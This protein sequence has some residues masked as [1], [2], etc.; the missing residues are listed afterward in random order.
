MI[1]N[2][3]SMFS[4]LIT[5][6]FIAV[7]SATNGLQLQFTEGDQI[8]T[9]WVLVTGDISVNSSACEGPLN[10]ET[11]M[12]NNQYIVRF[13]CAPQIITKPIGPAPQGCG[14]QA[15][16]PIRTR[17]VGGREAAAHS[18]PWLVSLQYAGEHFCGG[19]LIVSNEFHRAK[20]FLIDIYLG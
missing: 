12:Y 10:Y 8:C 9:A 18:W 7:A 5:I 1:F 14:R 13:C 17:I 20:T 19:T 6:A 4:F 11:R 16:N 3:I 15:V 2:N